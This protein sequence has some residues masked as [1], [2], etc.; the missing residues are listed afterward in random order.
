[1]I[2]CICV[3][4]D[5]GASRIRAAGAEED[6]GREHNHHQQKANQAEPAT[7]LPGKSGHPRPAQG[8]LSVGLAPG[9]EVVVVV[10]GRSPFYP[11]YRRDSGTEVTGP[12]MSS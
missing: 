6:D 10:H 5:G 2:G 12:G 1:V 8:L 7:V 4:V 3:G 11:L 9:V